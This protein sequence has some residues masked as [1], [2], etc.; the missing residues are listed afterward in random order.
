MANYATMD[1]ATIA[2]I[3]IPLVLL[4]L[5]LMLYALYDLFQEDRRVR[6]D[7]KIIWALIIA[8]ANGIGPLIYFF[9][10]RD[11]SRGA[12]TGSVLATPSDSIARILA[13]W[14][15]RAATAEAAV[16]TTGLTKRYGGGVVALE[17]LNLTV[18]SGSIFGFLGPNGAGKTTTLRLL[19][20]LATATAGTGSVAGVKIGGTG[21]ELARNIGYLDQDPRFYPWMRG[22]ELMNMVGQLHGL[23][24][25]A[26]KQRVGEVLEIVGLTDAAH[27][28]IGGY[29]GGM[30]QRLGIGQALINQP[31]V[32][33]LDEPVS[34]LDPEGRRDVLEIISRLRGTATV[35]MSTHILNDVERVCDRVA[36]LNL[37][38]LVVEGPIDELL[39]R[40]AQPIYEI[41]PEPQQ[42][43]SI[44]RLAAVLRGQAWAREVRTTP[45]TV[46]VFVDDPKVAGPAILP[47]V[48]SSGVNVVR[49]ERVRPSLE[50][51]FLRLVAESGPA[52]APAVTVPVWGLDGR[53]RR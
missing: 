4:E 24:G 15:V 53:G 45:D 39:D 11:E 35:F 42:P 52:I 6:G 21:G 18:P 33:F 48:A 46:R 43:G 37:G 30:R 27:R 20:G 19:T 36:I 34:S 50:D 13:T 7:S 9:V 29:S 41:E 23:R 2:L 51:V 8:F 16:S 32:L 22:R 12:A 31:R 44:D 10:G 26:L 28:R 1:P 38:H 49:Y 17:N 5:G 25:A 14:P 3:I 40:Y 47:L